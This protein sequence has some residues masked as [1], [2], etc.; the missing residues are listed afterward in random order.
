MTIIEIIII[1][2]SLAADAFAI[3]ICK[4]LSVSKLKIKDA[5]KC[6]IWFGVFQGLMPLI[7]YLLG[8]KFEKIIMNIDHWVAFILLFYIGLNML[9]DSFKKEE[10]IREDFSIK[11][12]FT[13]AVATSIDALA[14]GIAYVFA[15]G[16]SNSILCFLMIGIITFILSTIGVYIGNKFGNKFEK[17]SKIIGGSLLILLG[18]KILLEHLN[19]I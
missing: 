1:S 5:I 13:L 7:G 17:I 15:Y 12:M 9:L 3:S 19:I 11:T 16:S 18:L 2:I 8:Y 14:F 4:G 6:G 10:D